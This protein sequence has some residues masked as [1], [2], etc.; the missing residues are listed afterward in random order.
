MGSITVGTSRMS[1]DPYFRKKIYD[2]LHQLDGENNESIEDGVKRDRKADRRKA[3]RQSRRVPIDIKESLE[4]EI[5]A[6]EAERAARRKQR[7]T[8]RTIKT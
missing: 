6:R 2:Y 3:I 7:A 1:I 4:Q 5:K 8:K